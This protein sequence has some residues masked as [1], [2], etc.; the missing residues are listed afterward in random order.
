VLNLLTG[1]SVEYLPVIQ[2]YI[3]PLMEQ[4]RFR[5]FISF[6]ALDRADGRQQVPEIIVLPPGEGEM[7]IN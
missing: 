5:N 1:A 2:N 7:S 3:L 4:G 6:F